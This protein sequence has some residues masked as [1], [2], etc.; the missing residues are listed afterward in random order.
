[1]SIKKMITV[2]VNLQPFELAD[3]IW[4]STNKI[5]KEFYCRTKSTG[6]CGSGC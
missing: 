2:D 4:E 5:P 1:M 3:Y 6:F